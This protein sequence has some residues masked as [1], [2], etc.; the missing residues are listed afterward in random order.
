MPDLD[1]QAETGSVHL[2]SGGGWFG[3][4]VGHTGEQR[5]GEPFQHAQTGKFEAR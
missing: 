5:R 4:I 2:D 3:T 1:H